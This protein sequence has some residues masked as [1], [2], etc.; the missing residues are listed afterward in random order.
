MGG[1]LLECTHRRILDMRA[2]EMPV[3]PDQMLSAAWFL[4]LAIH[5]VLGPSALTLSRDWLYTSGFDT[6]QLLVR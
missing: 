6:G 5:R 3:L 1:A 4:D 2:A